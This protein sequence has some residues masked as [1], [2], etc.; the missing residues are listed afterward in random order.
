MPHLRPPTQNTSLEPNHGPIG[1]D[2]YDDQQNEGH[3][4]RSSVKSINFDQQSLALALHPVTDKIPPSRLLCAL[5]GWNVKPRAMQR[6]F[7]LVPFHKTLGKQRIRMRTDVFHRVVAVANQ[8]HADLVLTDPCRDWGVIAQF[9][10][11]ANVVPFVHGASLIK[12]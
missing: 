9:A 3:D 2:A 10:R 4:H 7:D 11:G 12:R 5:P 8:I 1:D 6:A